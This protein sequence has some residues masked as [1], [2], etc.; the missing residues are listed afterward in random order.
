MQVP[1]AW[2][3]DPQTHIQSLFPTNEWLSPFWNQFQKA[4][5]CETENVSKPTE[6]IENKMT[7]K[8]KHSEEQEKEKEEIKS[9]LFSPTSSPSLSISTPTQ[10]VNLTKESYDIRIDRKTKWGNPFVLKNKHDPEERIQRVQ[11]FR[12]WVPNQDHL[13]KDVHELKG[14]CLFFFY[15]HQ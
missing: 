6:T 9:I 2:L 11:Q 7:R 15:T 1:L 3:Q 12:D 4:F 10:V 8:R 14:L 13:M 5:A